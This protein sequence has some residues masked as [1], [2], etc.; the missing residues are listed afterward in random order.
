MEIK[1]MTPD[2]R[3][4]Y[5]M[6]S[7]IFDI[8][9]L[10]TAPNLELYYMYRDVKAQTEQGIRYDITVV[11]PLML[12]TEF[13][14]TKGHKHVKNQAEI[15]TVLE[16]KAIYLVQKQTGNEIQDVFAT[17]T[18]PGEFFIVPE[19]YGHITINPTKEKLVMANWIDYECENEYM[20]Y[21]KL[22]GAC[23]YYTKDGWIKNSSYVKVPKLR[24]EKPQ[25]Q[26]PTS[27]GFLRNP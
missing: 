4:L 3:R 5:D 14:K 8:K 10:M 9:W 25:K 26:L 19:G 2:V 22:R 27:L 17:E 11:P 24:F 1:D 12:G 20:L 15:Y 13:V 23:Y 6:K 21:E 18:N 7:V 16:G